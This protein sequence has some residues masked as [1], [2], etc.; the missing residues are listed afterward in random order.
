[1]QL[2]VLILKKVEL[3]HELMVELAEDG[4]HG[5]TIL[6]STGMAGE[7]GDID[8]IPMFSMLRAVMNNEGR[9]QQSKT[10]LFVVSDEELAILRKVM[11]RVLGD[12]SIPNTAV[13]FTV[14]VTSVEGLCD[15][16]WS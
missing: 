14:P 4:L 5:G 8:D 10:L 2:A 9:K 3:V 11:H 16:K 1:M 15:R 13:F 12:L 6:E 7:L